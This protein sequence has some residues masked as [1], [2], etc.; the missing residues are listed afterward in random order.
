MS[1]F[2]KA[3]PQTA[4]AVATAQISAQGEF[5][6]GWQ[7][8]PAF[9]LRAPAI[10]LDWALNK[11]RKQRAVAMLQ[12]LSETFSFAS[13]EEPEVD[14]VLLID[15]SFRPRDVEVVVGVTERFRAD[16]A[17]RPR[18]AVATHLYLAFGALW[19]GLVRQLH[20]DGGE[21]AIA[22][23][24]HDLQEQLGIHEQMGVSMR[25]GVAPMVAG[26]R[27]AQ[28]RWAEEDEQPRALVSDADFWAESGLD[29]EAVWNDVAGEFSAAISGK[30]AE[31]LYF[32]GWMVRRMVAHSLMAQ[33]LP[34]RPEL[35]EEADR[36]FFGASGQENPFREDT[37]VDEE[38]DAFLVR[39]HLSQ[40]ADAI[41]QGL[42]ADE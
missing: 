5:D 32:P 11:D 31:Q 40:I 7:G 24:L 13:V 23:L 42:S 37:A 25:G 29:V 2:K 41:C 34:L 14:L 10:Y 17:F 6:F 39:A 30:G 28:E 33:A 4:L 36:V 26:Q 18:V 38:L 27:G 35:A 3:D 22:A 12:T 16:V 21:D 9:A 19:N 1:L 8:D 20:R 15:G